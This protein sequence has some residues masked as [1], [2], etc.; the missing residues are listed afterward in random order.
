MLNNCN[1]AVIG[2]LTSNNLVEWQLLVVNNWFSAI[3]FWLSPTNDSYQRYYLRFEKA[4]D[5]IGTYDIVTREYV[6]QTDNPIYNGK[7]NKIR[8]QFTNK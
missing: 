8:T 7:F 5:M 6:D 2:Q 3:D 4:S 1:I